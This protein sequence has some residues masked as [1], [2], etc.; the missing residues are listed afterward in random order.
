MPRRQLKIIFAL[1]LLFAIFQTGCAGGKTGGA[2]MRFKQP[3]VLKVNAASA[4]TRQYAGILQDQLK[5]VGIP[6][7]IETVEF[8]TLLDQQRKGQ[9]QLTT[10]RWVG[11]NQDPIYLHDLFRT[12][13]YQNRGRYSNPELDGILDEAINTFDR[14]KAKE[15]YT[16]AQEIISRDVP[17]LPLWYV[18]QMVVTRRN[19]QNLNVPVDGDWRY[20]RDVT[21]E[22]EKQGPFVVALESNPETLDQLRGTD[23]SS[24][25]LRQL[26][27]NS[28]V[29]KNENFDYVGDIAS[30]IQTS[31]DGLVYT[32]KLRDGVKFHNGKAFTSA[33]AKYT[34]DTLLASDSRK[35]N[36]FFEGTA[37]DRKPLIK[38]IE[39]PDPFT[40]VVRLARQSNKFLSSLVPVGMMP[41]GYTTEQQK[42]T[43][44]GTGAFKF[45]R[46]DESQQVVDL[47]ANDS[48]WGGAP[49]LKQLRVRTILDANTLQAELRSGGIDL[50]AVANLQP[51]TYQ[52]L[53][54]DANLKVAQY[55]GVNVVYLSFNATA[56]PLSDAR[57]RQAI[58]YAIDRQALVKELLLGQARV[59]NSI[60]PEQSWAYSPGQ[61]Y[62]FDPEKAKQ[63]LDEAGYKAGQ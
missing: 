17:Q 31:T 3:L 49:A 36:D 24:E 38:S 41:Q 46:Y 2:A 51:D 15:L 34:L 14:A 11:G 57:V 23:A 55:P 5:Q 54:Q 29:R 10:G 39:T 7:E 25:R 27:F 20:L 4:P 22:G 53:G 18:D 26:M 19:V 58:A 33:D 42:Q 37:P 50:A 13:A 48:Y 9:F 12:G 45:V 30:D 35:A 56:E 52:A 62:N 59:A 1:I 63:I 21:V 16:H 44:I 8:N 47:A 28:L 40:L 43:P 60:L 61:V 6:C 32:F